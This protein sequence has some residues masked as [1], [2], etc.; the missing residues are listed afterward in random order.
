MSPRP[1]GRTLWIGTPRSR[2]PRRYINL[3]E[4]ATSGTLGVRHLAFVAHSAALCQCACMTAKR[5]RANSQRGTTAFGEEL[6]RSSTVQM[7]IDSTLPGGNFRPPGNSSRPQRVQTSCASGRSTASSAVWWVVCQV[8]CE[9]ELFASLCAGHSVPH[10]AKPNI[11]ALHTNCHEIGGADRHARA[12][13]TG[14]KQQNDEHGLPLQLSAQEMCYALHQ[15]ALRCCVASPLRRK[16]PFFPLYQ[17]Y[18]AG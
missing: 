15:G 14:Q 8:S 3:R 1:A 6:V 16:S 17:A 10:L 11:C 13:P 7:K 12:V 4:M 18:P 5:K 2:Q 9:P